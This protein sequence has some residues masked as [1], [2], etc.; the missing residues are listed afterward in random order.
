MDLIVVLDSLGSI[1]APEFQR[2][3][4]AIPYLDSGTRIDQAELSS[5]ASKGQYVLKL[6][7]YMHLTQVINSIT[8]LACD[9]PVFVPLNVE[10]KGEVS[11]NT[12]RYYELDTSALL[13]IAKGQG[14]L[15]IDKVNQY[16]FITHITDFEG[17][18]IG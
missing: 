14:I 6:T 12:Y 11:R 5:I 10:V 8:M 2:A 15:G 16:E 3:R 4:N 1:D 7:N 17:N 9:I 13:H 18:S